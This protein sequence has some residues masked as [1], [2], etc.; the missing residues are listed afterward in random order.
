MSA[1]TA[2]PSA[3]VLAFLSLCAAHGQ[4]P[5][6][7]PK[8]PESVPPPSGAVPDRSPNGAAAPPAVNAPASLSAY[9]VG[10]RP[11]YCCGPLG[12]DGP[13]MTEIYART[14]V[15]FNIG[16]GGVLDRTLQT[17]WAIEGGGR[18]LFFNPAMT[19]AWAVN[20]SISNVTNHGENPEIKA[21]LNVLVP[22]A[23]GGAPHSVQFG[24]NG[25]PGV[26]IRN[27]NRTFVNLG[28]GRDIYLFGSASPPG[29]PSGTLWRV[30]VDFG[31]RYG[32]ARLELEELRHRTDV[33]AGVWVGVH[34]DVEIPWG[35][36]T[37]VVGLRLEWDY[38]WSDILQ[39]QNDSDLMD[40]NLM[41]NFGVRF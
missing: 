17:G 39:I 1:K 32:T 15:S 24:Q 25:L 26:T 33:I 2:F 40:L 9:I 27:L 31:G 18:S 28:F 11:W 19:G 6:T 35:C 21:P 3:L 22:D 41:L 37:F 38:V 14:G 30:G 4:T 16:S 34:S 23:A 10:E 5:P 29:Q 36:S 13:V 7:S 8:L 20:Y 12:G